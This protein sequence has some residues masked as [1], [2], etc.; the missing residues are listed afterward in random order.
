MVKTLMHV[1]RV[2]LGYMVMLAVMSFNVGVFLVALA[3][4]GVGF[5]LFGSRVFRG[6]GGEKTDL[7]RMSC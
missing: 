2:G 1:V 7:P 5:F 6:E 3:G 4:H